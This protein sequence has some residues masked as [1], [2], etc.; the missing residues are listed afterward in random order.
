MLFKLKPDVTFTQL[1]EWKTLARAMVR[2]IPGL[3]QLE[4]NTPLASTAHRGMGFNMGMV[5][6]LEK[7]DDVSV[8]AK[9]PTHLEYGCCGLA[10]FVFFVVLTA[11]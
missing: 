11:V 8:Y 5:S 9:H 6:V 7:A 10:L 3:M 1:N 4:T 2:K